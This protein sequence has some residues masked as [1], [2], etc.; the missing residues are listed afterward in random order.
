MPLS[1]APKKKITMRFDADPNIDRPAAITLPRMSFAITGYQYDAERNLPNL[2]KL[3]FVNNSDAN[4]MK[5]SYVAAPYNISVELYIYVKNTEDG[6]KIIEQFL[7]FFKPEFTASVQ[8]IPE[9]GITHDIPIE[10]KSNMV[11]DVYEG[12]FTD[13]QYLMYT[14]SFLMRAYYYGPAYNKKIIKFANNDFYMATTSNNTITALDGDY[15][16]SIRV[17]PGL[18]ANGEPTSNASISIDPNEI[19]VTDDFGFV[20]ENTGIV[21]T[22]D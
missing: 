15:I 2:N 19:F 13:R 16:G 3:A 4:K 18:D 17:T 21:L 20:V 10:M 7:P 12:T 9:L 14:F 6:T 1:Y 22:E 5:Y 8:L 11:E